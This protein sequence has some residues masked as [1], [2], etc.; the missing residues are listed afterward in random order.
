MPTR[1]RFFFSFVHP[2]RGI[3]ALLLAAGILPSAAHAQAS[4]GVSGAS[5]FDNTPGISGS[6]GRRRLSSPLAI[7]PEDFATLRLAPGFLLSLEVYDTPELSSD[8][9]VDTNGNVSIPMIGQ[10]KVAGE[11]VAE[12]SDLIAKR[13]RDGK[14][15][16]NP[17]VTLSVTQYASQNIT[18]MGEVHSP[19]RLELLAPH[20]LTEV[21][22]NAG[23]ET[24]FAG[25]S[26]E[27]T[28]KQNG[29]VKVQTVRYNRD[30]GDL[31][32]EPVT[33]L[34]G[35][36]VNI[37][38]AGIVYVL[39]AVNRPGGYLMQESGELN[40]TQAIALAFGTEI[41]ASI[42]SMRL[43]RKA[44]DGRVIEQP[45]NYREMEKGKVAPPQLQAEDVIYVPVSK[46][47][48]VLSTGLFASAASAAVYVR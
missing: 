11:T 42:G 36:T 41:N 24:Q 45:I 23:G 12:A 6:S 43:I 29:M 39:G 28:R 26:V 40:V 48:T 44:P 14:F 1:K 30:K 27:I 19:G 8:L 25:N 38:R 18:V 37:R 34:P 9:R 4:T 32:A 21:I 20:S 47:K 15:L 10:I 31:E 3:F 46:A 7:V 33:I 2:S 13:F 5:S 22:A 35:D 17:Q 16:N